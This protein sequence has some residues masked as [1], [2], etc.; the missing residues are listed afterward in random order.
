MPFTGT[1]LGGRVFTDSQG[2]LTYYIRKRIN[3]RL[4]EWSTHCHTERAAVEELRRFETD[5][6]AYQPGNVHSEAL[7]LT[8]KLIDAFL[9]FSES[10]KKN[11]PKW[12]AKQRQILEWWMSKLPNKDLRKLTLRDDIVPKLTGQTRRKHRIAVIKM[13]Y[14]WLRKVEHRITNK[15]D[16]TLD[17]AVPQAKPAQWK[18]SKVIPPEAITA[19]L[20]ELPAKYSDGVR[21]LDAC[22]MHVTELEKFSLEGTVERQAGKWVLVLPETKIGG[23]HRM[24]VSEEIAEVAERVLVRG[25]LSEDALRDNIQK[26]SVPWVTPGCFRHTFATRMVNAGAPIEAVAAYLH[27]KSIQTTRK[28]YATLGVVPMPQPPSPT[29]TLRVVKSA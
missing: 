17:L 1:W 12:V 13:L 14:S 20:R 11:T 9:T 25:R 21:L 7:L 4:F 19:L 29:P 15:E 3:G 22:G 2:R 10:V 6:E 27:H 8:Q 16:P 23:M 28:F 18:K 5:P 26:T 24:H